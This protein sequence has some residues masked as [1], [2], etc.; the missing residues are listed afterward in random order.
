MREASPLPS[1]AFPTHTLFGPGAISTLP[2]RLQQ[3]GISRPL[4]VTDAG[5]VGTEA[6][7]ALRKMLGENAQDERWFL[8]HGVH[9]NPVERDVREAA[10]AFAEKNCDGVIGFGGGSPLDVGK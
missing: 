5:L 6:F 7:K 3:L 8:F 4:V 10:M 2:A 1:F 9:P